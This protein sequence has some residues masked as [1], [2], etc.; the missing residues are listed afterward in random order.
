MAAPAE[1]KLREPKYLLKQVARGRVPD[2]VIDRPKGYFPMP[3]LKYVRG[4]FYQFMRDI[5]TSEAAKK[6]GLFNQDY[7]ERLLEN[8]DA[9][10]NFTR[11]QGSKLW[12]AALTE[13]WLQRHIDELC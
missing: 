3:A 5:L 11:I 10:E 2:A 8:P 4:E 7:I 9:P 12:Q 13:L 1:L 6:R